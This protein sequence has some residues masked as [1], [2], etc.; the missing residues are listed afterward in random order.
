MEQDVKIHKVIS[1]SGNIVT[2]DNNLEY[3]ADNEICLDIQK[4]LATSKPIAVSLSEGKVVS[5][6]SLFKHKIK[7]IANT[8]D[9]YKISL[10]TGAAILKLSHNKPEFLSLLQEAQLNDKEIWIS[11]SAKGEIYDVMVDGK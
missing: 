2:L 5:I 3:Q 10:R 9:L 4:A 1:I 6:A 8:E 11:S 7:D